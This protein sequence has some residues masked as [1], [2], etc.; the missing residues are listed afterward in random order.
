[1]REVLQPQLHQGLL[2]EPLRPHPQADERFG[3]DE[4]VVEAGF[5]EG[6]GHRAQ[7]QPRR[8]NFQVEHGVWRP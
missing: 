2:G 7:D 1:M 6:H 5:E 8:E 4:V 3:R